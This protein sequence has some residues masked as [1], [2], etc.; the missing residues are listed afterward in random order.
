MRELAARKG[1]SA[2]QVA[3][4]WVLQKPFITAPIVGESKPSHLDDAVASLDLRLAPDEMMFLEEPYVPHEVTGV[5]VN[6]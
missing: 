2:A 5:V 1:C 6:Q 3:L 4:A